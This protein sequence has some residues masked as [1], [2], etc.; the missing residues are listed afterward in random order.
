MITTAVTPDD[1]LRVL[2]LR[3]QAVALDFDL[4]SFFIR[5]LLRLRRLA[6]VDLGGFITYCASDA[7]GA[8]APGRV[9]IGTFAR[10]STLLF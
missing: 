8:T 1:V 7:G 3:E 10:I 6:K 4:I 5:E 9:G 2:P